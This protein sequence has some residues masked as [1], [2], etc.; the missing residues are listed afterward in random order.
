M[1]IQAPN[2]PKQGAHVL[3]V[4]NGELMWTPIKLA[5]KVP[6]EKDFRN[7][8]NFWVSMQLLVDWDASSRQKE[9]DPQ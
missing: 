9:Y 4:S 7:A 6:P 1:T 5:Q 2:P 3:L 8:H